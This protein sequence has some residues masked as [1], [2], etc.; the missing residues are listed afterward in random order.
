M[1]D[2][3]GDTPKK[4]ELPGG[5][6]GFS[7]DP[8][9]D[10]APNPGG[11]DG[12]FMSFEEF[13]QLDGDDSPAADPLVAGDSGDLGDPG[14]TDLGTDLGTDL[15]TGFDESELEEFASFDEPE[16]LGFDEG[17]DMDIPE[18]PPAEALEG[19]DEVPSDPIAMTDSMQ[20]DSGPDISAGMETGDVP[21]EELTPPEFQVDESEDSLDEGLSLDP[22][23][24]IDSSDSLDDED[25]DSDL[26]EDWDPEGEDEESSGDKKS[27]KASKEKKPIEL[28]FNTIVIGGGVVLGVGVLAFQIMT[29][30]PTVQ[31]EETIQS[32]L[33]MTGA[34]GNPVLGERG[35]GGESSPQNT[36]SS[37]AG[38]GQGFL[39]NPDALKQ[40]QQRTEN[41]EA[42]PST[43]VVPNSS[44]ASPSNERAAAPTMP[45]QP[46]PMT[47]DSGTSSGAITRNDSSGSSN[48]RLTVRT[49]PPQQTTSVPINNQ[50]LENLSNQLKTLSGEMDRVSQRIGSLESKMSTLDRPSPNTGQ[51]DSAAMEQMRQSLNSLRSQVG[52]LE[53]NVARISS[54]RSSISEQNSSSQNTQASSSTRDVAHL[55]HTNTG[56]SGSSNNDSSSAAQGVSQQQNGSATV[57]RTP[58]LKPKS[59]ETTIPLTTESVQGGGTSVGSLV[60]WRLRSAQPGRAWVSRLGDNAITMIRVGNTLPGVGRITA[61]NSVNGRWVVRGEQAVITQ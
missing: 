15:D 32:A 49:T 3:P 38:A 28:S 1:S 37:G 59:W 5:D 52:S 19:L 54:E 60:K 42:S 22:S 40:A 48:Q 36:G 43:S 2:D 8:S 27:K 7:L 6:E 17:L 35:P 11:D 61:I 58:S 33:T 53:S 46:A 45:P 47:S 4:E 29:A 50:A 41:P 20:S 25:W 16:G 14:F 39:N 51:Q 12:D 57:P 26:D 23:L 31:R 18:N 21:E 9:S 44:G 10:A 30:Q 34:I 55:S 13:S 56:N 24:D